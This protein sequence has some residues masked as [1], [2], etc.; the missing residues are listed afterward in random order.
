MYKKKALVSSDNTIIRLDEN[1]FVVPKDIL[2]KSLIDYLKSKG[3]AAYTSFD[4]VT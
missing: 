2:S 3:G 1:F 4:V